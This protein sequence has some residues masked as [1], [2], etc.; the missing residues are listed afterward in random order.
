MKGADVT[1]ASVTG[2][3]VTGGSV[4]GGTITPGTVTPGTVTAFVDGREIRVKSVSGVSINVNGGN[5]EVKLGA[6]M[7]VIEKAKVVLDGKA[8]A[9][10][11]PASK[12]VE[13]DIKEGMLSVKADGKEVT[14]TKVK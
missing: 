9:N 12:K 1:G 2:G 5:A 6:Q 10:L 14:H 3:S 13:V 7:L 4:S 8:L 11:P